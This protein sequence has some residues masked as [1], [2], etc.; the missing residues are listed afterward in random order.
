MTSNK[1]LDTLYRRPG[2]LI[3]R[4]HQI[5][6]SL[7]LEETGELGITNRQYGIMLVLRHR[8]GIDQ[9]TVAK[10]L[11]LDRSTTGMVLTKLQQAGLVGRVVGETDRR[12]RSLKLTPAG[13]RMLA[14]LKQPA[15]RAQER[16]LSAFAPRERE[17]FLDLL[18]KF[19]QKFNDTTRV[20]QVVQN[21]SSSFRGAAK[22]RTRNP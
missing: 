1:T 17:M 4:A 10:L 19:A 12:K 6:V 13:E 21:P 3:R 15:R 5:S 8:P 16:V 11:G 7:F 9:I 14:R 2:F 22:R 18:D 20:P